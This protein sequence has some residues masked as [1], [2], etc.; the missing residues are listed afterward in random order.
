MRQ[1]SQKI[2]MEEKYT[3]KYKKLSL[4]IDPE[5]VFTTLFCNE[6]CAFWLDSSTAQNEF[7]RYS[8]MGVPDEILSYSIFE[9]ELTI[10][11]GKKMQHLAQDIFSYLKVQLAQRL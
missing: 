6:P 5:F 7:S 1:K 9:N 11:K 4:W 8:Y 2:S 10:Q 3:I